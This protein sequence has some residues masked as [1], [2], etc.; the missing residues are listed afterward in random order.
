MK[1]IPVNNYNEQYQKQK[2]QNFGAKLYDADNALLKNILGLDAVEDIANNIS[3]LRTLTGSDF[4]VYVD[5]F[6]SKRYYDILG[7]SDD[8]KPLGTITISNNI[9]YKITKEK[10]IQAVKF[11]SEGKDNVWI[12]K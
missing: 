9:F 12:Y 2:K 7:E 10:I 11:I 6:P 4:M 8:A 1:I 5:E 3:G